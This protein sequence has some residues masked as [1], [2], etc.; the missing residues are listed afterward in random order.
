VTG[1]SA[2][3]AALDNDILLKAA[4]YRLA[5]RFWP[6][7]AESPTSAV[8]GSARY[9]LTHLITRGERVKDKE[10]ATRALEEFFA[11]VLVLEPSDHELTAAAELEA[12]AQ[13]AG[14]EL[15]VGESQLAAIV[16]AREIPWLDTGDKR[17]VRGFE[18]LLEQS[19]T[20]ALLGARIRCLELLLLRTLEETPEQLDALARA[21]CAE[22]DLDKTASI[23]F[24]CYSGDPSPRLQDVRAGLESYIAALRAQARTVLAG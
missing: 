13:R 23:C 12:L 24:G 7:N 19:H 10:A 14:L 17:A 11:G 15:D 2:V 18:A 22:P 20:C 6:Q 4:C 21:V 8:L 16:A 3:Q 1:A 9:V 5:P